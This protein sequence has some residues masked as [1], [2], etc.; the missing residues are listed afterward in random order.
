MSLAA[1]I[2]RGLL[3]LLLVLCMSVLVNAVSAQSPTKQLSAQ[4]TALVRVTDFGPVGLTQAVQLHVRFDH[5]MV[6]FGSQTPAPVFE[7]NPKVAGRSRWVSSN[8]VVF[9]PSEN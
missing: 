3:S 7:I 5:A 8:V 4:P 2:H 9:E 1:Q 6:R